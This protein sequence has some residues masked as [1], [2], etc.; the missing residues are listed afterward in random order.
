M[1]STSFGKDTGLQARMLLTMFLLGLVY[2]AFVGV[3]F[4]SGASG[5]MIVIVA[6]GLVAVQLFAAEAIG[7]R[8][9]GAREVTPRRHRNCTR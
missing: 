1:R 2:V 8:A 7:L 6:G 5:V 9:M 3:L 4:A